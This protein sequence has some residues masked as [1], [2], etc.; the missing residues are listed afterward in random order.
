MQQ[1]TPET[2]TFFHLWNNITPKPKPRHFSSEAAGR[3]RKMPR[4]R[5]YIVS[6]DEKMSRFRAYVVAYTTIKYCIYNIYPIQRVFW[7]LY[8]NIYYKGYIFLYIPPAYAGYIKIYIPHNMRDICNSIPPISGFC[9]F[10]QC[11]IYIYI[12]LSKFQISLSN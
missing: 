11:H 7:D 3:G 9:T 8:K 12:Y 6:E 10:Q 2:G 1:Y 5:G 4:L